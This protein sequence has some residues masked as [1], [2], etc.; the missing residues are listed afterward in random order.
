[1]DFGFQY[2]REGQVWVNFFDSHVAQKGLLDQVDDEPTTSWSSIEVKDLGEKGFGIE[3]WPEN[4]N[5]SPF[6][7][8]R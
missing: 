6:F 5:A 1:L 3:A 7:L 4:E 2:F 8:G